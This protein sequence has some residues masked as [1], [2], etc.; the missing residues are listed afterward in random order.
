MQ[1]ISSMSSNSTIIEHN[2]Y[3]LLNVVIETS[4]Y[5]FVICF[6]LSHT[7]EEMEILIF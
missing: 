2:K 4:I 3:F 5:M 6:L 1:E 7:V